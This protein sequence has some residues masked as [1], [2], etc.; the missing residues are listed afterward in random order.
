APDEGLGSVGARRIVGRPA[1]DKRGVIRDGPFAVE[2]VTPYAGAFE[3][4]Q[5][6]STLLRGDRLLADFP[7]HLGSRCCS[8][9]SAIAIG[10]HA[11]QIA[12][13]RLE[14][15]PGH[16]A[17]SVV[18]NLC[19]RAAGG[20]PVLGMARRQ[21]TRELLV[22]PTADAPVKIG[23]DVVGL[24]ALDNCAGEL[25]FVVQSKQDV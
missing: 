23:G 20:A 7:R 13:D 9:V 24:P 10:R 6:G 15:W 1:A 11:F 22:G 2:L 19:N 5:A 18:E 16:I 8:D 14:V 12:C 25:S 17:P 4:V 21:I 3:N